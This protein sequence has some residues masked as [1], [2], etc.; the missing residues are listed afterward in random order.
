MLREEDK[1]GERTECLLQA[2][3]VVRGREREIVGRMH[4]GLVLF[5]GC[6]CTG[7]HNS[8]AI[9]IDSFGMSEGMCARGNGCACTTAQ[10]CIPPVMP[11]PR[12]FF[13][14]HVSPSTYTHRWTRSGYREQRN[15][16]ISAQ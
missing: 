13:F 2:R 6:C 11:D 1:Q 4:R 8:Q 10:L 16:K 15:G 12:F 7:A 3:L 5:P 9:M 14:L